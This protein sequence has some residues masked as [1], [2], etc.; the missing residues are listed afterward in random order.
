MII[1]YDFRG[2]RVAI[3]GGGHETARKLRSFVDAGA[4]V[5][6]FGPGFDEEAVRTAKELRVPVIRCPAE[7]LARRAF[8]SSD[9]VVVVADDRGLGR[10]LRPVANRR[11]IPFYA[12]DDP[13]VSDWVQP[14]VRFVGPVSVAVSTGGESPIVARD[15]AGRLSQEIRPED[16]LAVHVQSYARDLAKRRIGS[17][18][19]RRRVL[20]AIHE[21]PEV[22]A[23]LAGGNL[24]RAKARAK[25]LVLGTAGRGP[26]R[27]GPR[28]TRAL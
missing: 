4:D 1:D 10:A 2:K 18:E 5:R 19:A 13:A 22:R 24:A 3:V 12:A 11:R 17:S 6:L 7:Q 25:R 26:N 8:T 16:E 9:A 15:L 14:A 27:R 28:T 20:Y 21:D 23:A